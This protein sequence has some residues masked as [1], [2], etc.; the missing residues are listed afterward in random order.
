MLLEACVAPV[1][2]PRLARGGLMDPYGACSSAAP[3]SGPPGAAKNELKMFH[4]FHY[5]D[6]ELVLR[7]E[8]MIARN[9]RR[10]I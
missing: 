5:G 7:L 9:G 1:V 3:V 6:I 2:A 8:L 10:V 4:S